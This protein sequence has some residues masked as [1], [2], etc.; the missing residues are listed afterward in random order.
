MRT[1]RTPWALFC[2][3]SALSAAT[4]GTVVS[5]PGGATYSD[6]VLD[7]ARSRLYL[8]N[9][10]GNRVEIYNIRTKAFL[11]SIATDLQPVS[12]A[13][14]RDGNSLFVTAYTSATL[15]VIDLTAGIVTNRVSLPTNPEGL[16]VGSDGRALITA[17]AAGTS[18][19][20]TLLIFD[21][22]A[23]GGTSLVSV[24]VLPPPS[25]PPVLP[26][27]SGRVFVSYR[28]RLLATPDGKWIIGVNG[29]SATGKAVFVFE[30]ASGTVL[31]SRAVVNLSTTLAVTADGSKFMAGSTLFDAQT[32]QVI[33]QENSANAAFS[34]TGATPPNFNLQ[35]NEGGSVS[36][37]MALSSMPPS[38]SRP[39]GRCG[40]RYRN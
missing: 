8:V 11:P 13:L 30:A 5:P 10:A 32:L 39:W 1:A 33:A 18:T 14:S 4:F 3:A 15:D 40:L 31:R 34:F 22:A 26:M 19:A 7:E 6:I 16:A 17:V 27:P 21:P 20:N 24:P 37:P 9:S 23:A 25:T 12:A 28:S 36:L 29:T 38:T 2:F 35:Q